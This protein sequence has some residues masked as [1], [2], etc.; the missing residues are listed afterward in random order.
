MMGQVSGNH[1]NQTTTPTGAMMMAAVA[2]SSRMLQKSATQ[3][4]VNAK[5]KLRV[6]CFFNATLE[7]G[8]VSTQLTNRS[9]CATFEMD[10]ALA[11]V[12]VVLAAN[13]TELLQCL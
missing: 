10:D 1:S 5:T 13:L 12:V 4:L 11:I 8:N 7:R 6:W 9:R 2:G 3:I